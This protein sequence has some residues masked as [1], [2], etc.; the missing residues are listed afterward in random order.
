MLLET[1]KNDNIHILHSDMTYCYKW[2][3]KIKF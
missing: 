3:A 2:L 1:T